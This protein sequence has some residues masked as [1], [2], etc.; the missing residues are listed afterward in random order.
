MVAP[1]YL[2]RATLL[3]IFQRL[4]AALCLF[5]DGIL[6]AFGSTLASVLEDGIDRWQL[7]NNS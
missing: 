6:E 2:N 7:S 4:L 3:Q 5:L 1:L